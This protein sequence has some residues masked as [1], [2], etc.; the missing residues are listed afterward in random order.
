MVVVMD[1][2]DSEPGTGP[3]AIAG[4]LLCNIIV[5][6]QR[7]YFVRHTTECRIGEGYGPKG[8]PRCDKSQR[9][10]GYI[11]IRLK[12]RILLACYGRSNRILRRC[13]CS[14]RHYRRSSHHYHRS[15]CRCRRGH[16]HNQRS[17]GE[18]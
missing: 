1:N 14:R 17:L 9:W 5:L 18:N 10:S 7:F 13:R 4:N 16:S 15:S 8:I 11:N 6:A 12:I 3:S 2:V